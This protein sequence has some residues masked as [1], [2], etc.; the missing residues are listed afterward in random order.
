MSP[1]TIRKKTQAEIL[2][3]IREEQENYN[4]IKVA[5]AELTSGAQSATITTG[6]GSQSYTRA[7]L[8]DIRA[9]LRVSATRINRLIRKYNGLKHVGKPTRTYYTF[10]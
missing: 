5:I 10:D 4:A 6:S 7:S 8:P 2:A 1:L 3:E 9:L